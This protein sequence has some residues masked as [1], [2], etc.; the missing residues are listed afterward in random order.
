[1]SN[2]N[3]NK[4]EEKTNKHEEKDKQQELLWCLGLSLLIP[5]WFGL[6][7]V[8]YDWF[9]IKDNGVLFK[10]LYSIINGQWLVNI[11]ICIIGGYVTFCWCRKIWNDNN[12][13]LYRPILIV[14][15]LVALLVKCGR[16]NY[17]KVLWEFDYRMYCVISLA[18]VL[19]V[20]GCKSIKLYIRRH[21]D[22]CEQS[23]KN[24]GFSNDDSNKTLPENLKKYAE[25]IIK[26]V[27]SIN[28][29]EQSYAIGITGEW[30]VGKTTFLEELTRNIGD[31]ADLVNFNPWMCRTPEQVTHDFFASLRKNLSPKYS[32][33]SRSIRE[34]AKYVSSLSL[35]QHSSIKIDLMQSAKQES[36]DELKNALSAKFKKLPRPVVVI[37]DDIDRLERDEVF[38]VLRLIRNTA[39]LSNM[40]YLVA[41]D[42]EYVTTVLSEK[43][44]KDSSAYLEKIFQVEVHLPKVEDQLIWET[45]KKEIETQISIDTNISDKDF[46]KILF[47]Q[48]KPEEREII[49]A[50][51]DNYRRAKRF[52]RIFA[53]NTSYLDHQIKGEVKLMDVFWL[54]LLQI[55][56]KR[57]YDVLANESTRL[58]YFKED[59]F[60]LRDGILHYSKDN[61]NNKNEK[62]KYE[63]ERLW[64]DE[65][66]KILDLLFGKTVVTKKQSVCFIE[67]FNKYF[68]MSVSPFRLSISE[69]NQ[70]FVGEVNVEELVKKWLSE[71]Y[72]SSIA[73]QFR[74]VLVNKLN[75][76][77]LSAFLHGVM[78]FC[79]EVIPNNSRYVLEV[80]RMLIKE[81]YKPE[82]AKVAH[83]EIMEWFVAKSNEKTKL[84]QLGQLLNLLYV[85]KFYDEEGQIEEEESLVISNQEVESQ[86]ENMMRLYL[87][88]H[89]E[90]SALDL[91]T[92]SSNLAGLFGNCCVVEAAN[93]MEAVYRY[94][95]V[96]FDL[97]T[98]HFA[99]KKQKPSIKEYDVAYKKMFVKGTPE[100]NDEKTEYDYWD[101][102][103]EELDHKRSEYFGS[104]YDN[105]QNSL[106][107]EF[108][109]KCFVQN[110]VEKTES[111]CQRKELKPAERCRRKQNR[112][113]QRKKHSKKYIK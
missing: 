90:L 35:A 43:N 49:L 63:G 27:L 47:D 71:K 4:D 40:I 68:M 93:E 97:V 30:G 69:M 88:N 96:V 29:N 55:Y 12:I 15:G 98:T 38:E 105:K 24:K 65:S 37:I 95:Q 60:Y 83:D 46:A 9:D 17:S 67:N 101:Y 8:W 86:M 48:F 78:T 57:T 3:N 23:D 61:D 25:V 99:Q 108:K 107:N 19:V 70:I 81:H 76:S 52:A 39:D 58:L 33:L 18:I 32:T 111:V 13:R 56:D 85:T 74:H 89:P 82:S 31:Q 11:P 21:G 80:K 6:A 22:E 50:V 5:V 42:K 2:Y 79:I 94:K 20:M 36:L 104:S 75:D 91:M 28:N 66:P 1:M 72:Y 102:M 41:Y 77:E 106:L 51:L 10:N 84:L 44:I 73:Y 62:N 110:V 59:R 26:R 92:E 14:I 64:N 7:P 109:K 103:A 113:G 16:V 54:E 112:G 100:F 53:L 34:Y 87:E 45:L